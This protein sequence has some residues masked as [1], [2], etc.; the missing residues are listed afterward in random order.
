M[1]NVTNVPW[2]VSNPLSPDHSLEQV[3][4]LKTI[5]IS[6]GESVTLILI[7]TVIAVLFILTGIF[8]LK[9]SLGKQG[10]EIE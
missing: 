8:M 10:V 7:L 3:F 2:R 6:L 1:N 9:I 4:L 5:F